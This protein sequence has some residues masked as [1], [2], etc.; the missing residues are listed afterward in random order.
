MLHRLETAEIRLV[1]DDEGRLAEFTHVT[2]DH[3]YVLAPQPLWRLFAENGRHF[4]DEL[5]PAAKPTITASNAELT[6]EYPSLRSANVGDVAVRLRCGVRVEGDESQ[7]WAEVVNE[8][9]DTL[10]RDLQFPLLRGLELLPDQ[11]LITSFAGGQRHRDPKAF[12]RGH[13]PPHHHWYITNDHEGLQAQ[14]HYPGLTASM[15]CFALP[16]PEAGLYFGSHDATFRDTQHVWRL[17][18]DEFEA[19]LSKHLGLHPGASLQVTGYVV[20]AYRG[21]WHSAAD[22]Y[23]HWADTWWRPISRPAWMEHYAGWQRLILRH[24]DGTVQFPY[25]SLPQVFADGAAAGVKGLFMFAWWPE[26]H[27]QGYPHYRPD[28]DMGGEAG[29]RENIRRFQDELGGNV[30]LYASG[31]LVDIRSSFFAGQGQRLAIK[32]RGG[33]F[34]R[35]YYN[36]ANHSTYSRSLGTVELSPMCLESEEW[37]AVLEGVI[38][39]AADYG[40][41]GVFFDQLGLSEHPCH[42]P[43]HGH[44]VPYLTS[45]AGKRRIVERLRDYARARNPGLAI[46]VEVFADC[47][48][49]KFD[50]VH[51]WYGQG[52]VARNVDYQA[53]G[54]RPVYPGFFEWTRYAFPEA[55]V[56]DRDIRDDHDVERRVNLGLLLGLFPDVE[57]HRCRKTIAAVP[58]YQAWLGEV[59]ALRARHADLLDPANYRDTLGFTLDSAEVDARAFVHGD[60]LAVLVTQSHLASATAALTVPGKRFV[61]QDGIGAAQ[62]TP[63]PASGGVHLVLPRHAIA[64]A[65][66]A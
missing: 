8:T 20:A 11:Q 61:G 34:L 64:L 6:V 26:G 9:T 50:F 25:D 32:T 49:D 52:Y 55:L 21:T 31:R 36:F 24:Q 35:E 57:I 12:V 39:L 37:I 40:C 5:F 47:V 41:R 17:R 53:R 38:D 66:F 46:G 27:D 56:S 19:G 29:L 54:E 48:A 65:I 30:I 33:A 58:H 13:Y 2:Q 23:R 14:L 60:R 45:A 18:G 42:D 16:A 63:D 43:S 1:L 7:W 62:V 10:V 22:K 28:P 3:P 59:N 44:P 15:N 51:G 4:Q